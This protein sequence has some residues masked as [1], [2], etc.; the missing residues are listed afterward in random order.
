MPVA[1]TSK[2]SYQNLQ[3]SGLASSCRERIYQAAAELRT[4]TRRQL[5]DATGLR[6]NQVAGRVNELL[7]CGALVRAGHT[8]DPHTGRTVE[9]LEVAA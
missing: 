8:N 5:E 7:K 2:S 4:C 1:E 9:L 3:D 6:P